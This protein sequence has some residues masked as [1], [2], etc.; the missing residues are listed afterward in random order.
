MAD[1]PADLQFERAEPTGEALPKDVRCV[2]CRTQLSSYFEVN[3]NV[4][5]D[6]CKDAAMTHQNASHAPT[7]LRGAGLGV[8]AAAV[9]AGIYYAIA[10][11]TGYEFGLMSIVLGL[12]VGFA[13]RRGA[14]A[15]GGWR[16][17]TLAMFLCYAAICATY[18]PRVVSAIRKQEAQATPAPGPAAAKPAAVASTDAIKPAAATPSGSSGAEP[19]PTLSGFFKAIA[20]LFVFSLALP[21]LGGFDNLMGIVI[22]GIGLYEAWK[23]N[24]AAPFSVSGPFMVG[25]ARGG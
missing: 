6:N 12:M 16:Y 15:R 17:Q 20:M 9:G 3:G 1:S 2:A 13:V 18:V 10:E 7:L 25:E 22:I 5:C 21:F 23:V 24:R 11:V 8:L 19:A 14:R 4:A